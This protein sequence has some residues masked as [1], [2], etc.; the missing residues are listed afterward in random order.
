MRKYRKIEYITNYLNL[1]VIG[2]CIF[3]YIIPLGP[4][5]NYIIYCNATEGGDTV[6]LALKA[7]TKI[8]GIVLIISI[9]V[10]CF[11]R[12]KRQLLICLSIIIGGIAQLYYIF[13]NNGISNLKQIERLDLEYNDTMSAAMSMYGI[14]IFYIIAVIIV[15]MVVSAV[16]SAV[17]S[18]TGKFENQNDYHLSVSAPKRFNTFMRVANIVVAILFIV[19]L[20][21]CALNSNYSFTDLSSYTWMIGLIGFTYCIP[22]IMLQIVFIDNWIKNSKWIYAAVAYIV[23]GYMAYTA[24]CK[25]IFSSDI[26]SFI[27]FAIILM[28]FA[29]MMLLGGLSQKSGN[30]QNDTDQHDLKWGSKKFKGVFIS[31]GIVLGMVLIGILIYLVLTYKNLAETKNDIEYPNIDIESVI[32]HNGLEKLALYDFKYGTQGSIIK[33]SFLYEGELKSENKTIV[34]SYEGD[35]IA[36]CTVKKEQDG[37]SDTLYYVYDG[38]RVSSIINADKKPIIGYEYTYSTGSD[39]DYALNYITGEKYKFDRFFLDYCLQLM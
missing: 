34:F 27:F 17:I 11:I 36:T 21:S 15:L 24:V 12:L 2:L 9:A 33:L 22:M 28:L 1:I 16:V 31:V 4:F 3:M 20:V 14:I 7:S 39:F 25:R 35:N 8:L 6:D 30:V 23:Y 29:A 26:G 19:L 37:S 5:N 13:G 32:A 38:E 10:L 18:M